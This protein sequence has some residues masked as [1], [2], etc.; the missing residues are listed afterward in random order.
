MIVEPVGIREQ[1]VWAL[2]PNDEDTQMAAEDYLRM[3]I[4]KVKGM[5][6][7]E[8]FQPEEEINKG[9]LVVGGGV[10]GLTAARE[11]A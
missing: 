5:E 4:A 7:S 11:A 3:Y 2:P 1:V 10:A 6:P 9:I 8:P